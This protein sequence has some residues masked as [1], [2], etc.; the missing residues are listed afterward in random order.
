M[1]TSSRAAYWF[2]LWYRPE[3]SM[4]PDDW[5]YCALLLWISVMSFALG[6][7]I[8]LTWAHFL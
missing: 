5:L 4:S 1:S 7:A 2:D 8:G 3:Y 6:L